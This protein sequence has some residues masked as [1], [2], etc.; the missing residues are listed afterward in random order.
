MLESVIAQWILSLSEKHGL[1]PAQLMGVR[2]GRS[3]NAALNFLIEQI[4]ATWQNKGSV[5]L[6]QLHDMTGAYDRIVSAQLLYNMRESKIPEWIVKWVGSFI[7][8]RTTTLYL[9]GHNTNAFST[10]TEIS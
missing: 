5:A 1:L 8:N 3:T 10:H 9:P 6:L 4:H 7:S 2:H